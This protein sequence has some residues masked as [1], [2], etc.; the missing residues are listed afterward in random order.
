MSGGRDTHCVDDQRFGTSIRVVR[1][2]RGWRQADLAAKSG[3]S[4][5][6]ISRLE[7][8]HVGPQSIE[9]IRAV[10]AALEMRVDLTPRW[11]AGDLDR[12]LNSKHSALH[13]SVARW[14]QQALPAWTLAPEVSFAI[15]S[16]RGVVDI[17]G[18]HPGRRALLVVELKTD[19]ADLNELLGTLD[20]KRRV[21][22]QVGTGRSWDPVTVSAWLVVAGSRTNRRRVEAH[23]RMLRGTLPDDGP[24]I[25]H[26][27]RDPIG[28]VAALSFW[29]NSH[30][31]AIGPAIRPIRRVRRLARPEVRA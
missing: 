6:A 9:S 13:E 14:F 2:R 19:L 5:T 24:T 22:A 3:V 26:W 4:Q 15:Y 16:D 11:R 29:S 31:A 8:G 28:K 18:W 7:R 27:L 25:R 12:L 21:A 10:A 23:D 17:L 1:Q 20:R 30:D